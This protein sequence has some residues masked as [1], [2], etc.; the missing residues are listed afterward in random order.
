MHIIPT[1]GSHT[2]YVICDD[3]KYWDGKMWSEKGILYYSHEDAA[4]VLRNIQLVKG[5]GKP[6]KR[7][8]AALTLDLIGDD[9]DKEELIKYLVKEARLTLNSPNKSVLAIQIDWGTLDEV[10]DEARNTSTDN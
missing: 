4:K 7:Y 1:T 3:K 8:Q 6:S 10:K 5:L 9:I 2:R